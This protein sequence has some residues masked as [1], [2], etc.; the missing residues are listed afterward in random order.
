VFPVRLQLDKLKKNRVQIIDTLRANNIGVGVHFMP[1][2]Q[3]L[4]Y[5]KT[6]NLK[7]EDFPVAS[8][9]FPKLISLPIYPSM[10]DEDVDRVID[11]FTDIL[12]NARK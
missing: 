6:F 5:R 1:V 11:V 7:D 2:H 10:S 12:K 9:I 8:G 4:Y 3:H